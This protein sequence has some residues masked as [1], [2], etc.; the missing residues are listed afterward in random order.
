MNW[1]VLNSCL[2]LEMLYENFR[3]TLGE[4]GKTYV[5]A[6][7]AGDGAVPMIALP[8]LAEYTKW[9]FENPEEARG[10]IIDAATEHVRWN[11]VAKGFT[12]VT[13]KPAIVQSITPRQFGEAVASQSQDG[14]ETRFG[15]GGMKVADN[16]TGF[17]EVH[18][19]AVPGTQGLWPVDYAR[20]DKIFPGRV[21]SI[22]DWMK[23]VNYTGED[24]KN[25]LRTKEELI[26]V[27]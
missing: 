24:V 4:D 17:M 27:K 11:D 18:S 3:P 12:D 23:K 22:G 10:A 21:K 26:A 20:L 8:D 25:V 15:A 5:F 19:L 1:T 13:G 9:V 7:A 6:N 16:F 14:L 2:Y